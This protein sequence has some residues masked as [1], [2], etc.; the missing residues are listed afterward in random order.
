LGEIGLR[1]RI[2]LR[3]DPPGIV[4]YLQKAWHHRRLKGAERGCLTLQLAE[5]SLVLGKAKAV[6]DAPARRLSGETAD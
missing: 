1:R 6:E 4:S 2:A 5:L 3:H